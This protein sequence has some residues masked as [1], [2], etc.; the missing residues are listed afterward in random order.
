MRPILQICR[1]HI[2]LPSAAGRSAE[3]TAVAGEFVPV[4]QD[5]GASEVS[6]DVR[7]GSIARRVPRLES[8]GDIIRQH[9]I[10]KPEHRRIEKIYTVP[11]DLI[12]AGA[13]HSVRAAGAV[14][15]APRHNGTNIRPAQAGAANREE[16]VQRPNE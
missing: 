7:A 4:D 13:R 3:H 15:P 10:R 16:I 2:E 1:V 6:E 14:S 12:E 11:Y 5:R 9:S 8:D